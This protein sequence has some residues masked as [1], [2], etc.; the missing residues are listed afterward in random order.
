LQMHSSAKSEVSIK[1]DLPSP[2]STPY[3][4]DRPSLPSLG[5]DISRPPSTSS[6]A[7]S[8]YIHR[9]PSPNPSLQ[10]PGLSQLSALASVATSTRTS[11]GSPRESLN[12][13]NGQNGPIAQ[14]S[15]GY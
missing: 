9:R 5:L 13:R 15:H 3:S 12:G 7:S 6:Q 8:Q 2:A 10:L 14:N 4:E 11:P 1:R